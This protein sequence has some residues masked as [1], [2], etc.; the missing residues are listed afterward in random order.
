MGRAV[1]LVQTRVR[2]SFKSGNLKAAQN[3]SKL[4]KS[5]SKLQLH[6]AKLKCEASKLAQAHPKLKYGAS[7]AFLPLA[8][9][10]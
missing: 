9:L 8:K 1:S 5:L 10:K 2:G 3:L 7:K 6:L 4:R